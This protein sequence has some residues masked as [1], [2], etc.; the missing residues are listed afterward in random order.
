MSHIKR[1]YRTWSNTLKSSLT[2]RGNKPWPRVLE[3]SIGSLLTYSLWRLVYQLQMSLPYPIELSLFLEVVWGT[4]LGLGP[5]CGVAVA[6]VVYN[7]RTSWSRD[8]E[9]RERISVWQALRQAIREYGLYPILGGAGGLVG[10]TVWW[11]T[12]K[13]LYHDP[14]TWVTTLCW[15]IVYIGA[16]LVI[17]FTIKRL[18]EKLSVYFTLPTLMA[19]PV[20]SFLL[21]KWFHIA[22]DQADVD[23]VVGLSLR[24]SLIVGTV[25]SLPI[26]ELA[27]RPPYWAVGEQI[28]LLVQA[29]AREKSWLMKKGILIELAEA[30]TYSPDTIRKFCSGERRPSAKVTKKLLELGR[31][32]GLGRE[33]GRNLLRATNHFSGKQVTSTLDDIFG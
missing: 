18:T 10:G 14:S 13:W 15:T 5:F 20:A 23:M 11:F 28:N 8:P 24:I 25:L 12:A 16:I 22:P 7:L 9:K 1:L 2:V 31:E 33:W 4:L 3:A 32:Y 27:K 6:Q 29:M 17:P 26:P 21:I 19:L 30:L